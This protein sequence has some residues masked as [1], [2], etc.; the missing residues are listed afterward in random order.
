MRRKHGH[1]LFAR[2]EAGAT[3]RECIRSTHTRARWLGTGLG[4]GRSYE[5]KT[6][7]KSAWKRESRR[8]PDGPFRVPEDP[9]RRRS[10]LPS[11]QC[12]TEKRP[13]RVTG[14]TRRWAR[15]TASAP[16]ASTAARSE[17]AGSAGWRWRPESESESESAGSWGWRWRPESESESAGSLGWRWRPESESES[18]SG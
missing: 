13:R 2:G 15:A 1:R 11:Q 8:P 17:S 7:P 9:M 4:A 5:P 12:R 10:Q 6:P 14:S 18:E 16:W 3:R